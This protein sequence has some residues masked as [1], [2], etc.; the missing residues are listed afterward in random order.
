M[1]PKFRE[2]QVVNP[3]KEKNILSS[4][5]KGVNNTLFDYK[6]KPNFWQTSDEVIVH[7]AV[8]GQSRRAGKVK[9]PD[10]FESSCYPTEF[11]QPP[12]CNNNKYTWSN[13]KWL[14]LLLLCDILTDG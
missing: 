2:K 13:K 8:G 3:S 6:K 5:Q 12:F 7:L 9:V 14:R 4:F 1:A 11:E 10:E